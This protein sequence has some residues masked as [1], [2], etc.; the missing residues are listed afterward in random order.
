MAMT[1]YLKLDGIKGE[2]TT[3]AYKDNIAVHSFSWS[4]ATPTD[5]AS[6]LPSG[7]TLVS[8]MK[9]LI[10]S[11]IS[12]PEIAASV[13]SN[14]LFDKC[15]LAIKMTDARGRTS[16]KFTVDMYKVQI[17]SLTFGGSETDKAPSDQVSL[18]FAKIVFADG[19]VKSSIEPNNNVG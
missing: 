4:E 5:Q 17:D 1:M 18:N 3:G 6:G 10:K 8:P 16:K 7:R 14:K 13:F 9:L 12:T 15:T 19:S 11:G 2:V